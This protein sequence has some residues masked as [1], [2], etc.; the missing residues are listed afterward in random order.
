METGTQNHE[1]LA[2]WLGTVAYLR[3]IGDGD[4][5]IAMDRIAAYERELTRYA[6]TKFAERADR[7]ALY[8]RD[9][10]EARLPVFGFNLRGE[11]PESVALALDAAKIEASVGDYYAPRLI[12]GLAPETGGNA[13]RISFAHY[14]DADDVDR[15][16]AAIDA[17]AR[18][19]SP[20]RSSAQDESFR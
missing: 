7:I 20:V 3:S 14:N 2:G 13:V 16:F 11:S 18:P 6:G 4:A 1:G 15:C 17:V 8:G 12:Q 9:G 5:R 19:R 10:N